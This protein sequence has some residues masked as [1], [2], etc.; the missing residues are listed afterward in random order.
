[1][2]PT[3]LPASLRWI[4][5]IQKK[6][7]KQ[8]KKKAF[9]NMY[10]FWLFLH[11]TFLEGI[12]L[13]LTTNMGELLADVSASSLLTRLL[14]RGAHVKLLQLKPPKAKLTARSVS[15][16]DTRWHPHGGSVPA[17]SHFQSG[18]KQSANVRVSFSGKGKTM[19][20]SGCGR[21]AGNQT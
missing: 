2:Q 3:G 5:A 8:K 12:P 20:H 7:K 9:Q 15:C 19:R 18:R 16:G 4:S 1:M 10:L 14:G 17:R 11:L 6:K 21:R 13:T